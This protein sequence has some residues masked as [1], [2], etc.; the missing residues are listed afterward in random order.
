[1]AK[2]Q[3]TR[4]VHSAPGQEVKCSNVAKASVASFPGTQY[5]TEHLGTRLLPQV[6]LSASVV[7]FLMQQKMEPERSQRKV[8]KSNF[9]VQKGDKV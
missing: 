9:T 6:M 4:G 8:P 5:I 2:I 3:P 7:S 1:M